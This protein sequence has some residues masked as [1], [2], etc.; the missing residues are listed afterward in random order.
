MLQTQVEKLDK[1]TSD[2]ID[3]FLRNYEVLIGDA[4]E[5][6]GEWA[7]M[8]EQEQIHH[9]SISMQIWGMRKTLGELYRAGRLTPDEV[10]RLAD[11]DR[12]L[13]EEAANVEVAYGPSLRDLVARLL[14]WGTPL[15]E[16]EGTVWLEVP[17]RTLPALAQV[18]A[19]ET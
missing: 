2:W 18:L 7:G 17:V 4:A 19:G 11:L 5:L 8:D 16:A 13:L 12:A 3:M 14:D 6:A 1:Y 15:L 10:A 9:R